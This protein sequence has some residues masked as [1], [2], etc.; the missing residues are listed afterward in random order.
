MFKISKNQNIVFATNS[1]KH[2]LFTVT[3]FSLIF[4][5]SSCSLFPSPSDLII[6]PSSN[7]PLLEI[8]SQFTPEKT[9]LISPDNFKNH[10]LYQQYD[11]DG[12]HRTEILFVYQYQ[13]GNH[14]QSKIEVK[15]IKEFEYGWD[16]IWS[17]SGY[18]SGM[19]HAELY[20]LTNNSIPEIILGWSS[21]STLEKGL[22]I[23]KFTSI[24]DFSTQKDFSTIYSSIEIQS[25]KE[26]DEE[27]SDFNKNE[28]IIWKK[29]KDEAFSVDI[30]RFQDSGS[31]IN[32]SL[33]AI[34]ANENYPYFFREIAS[35]YA[36]LVEKYPDETIYWYYYSLYLLYSHQYKEALDSCLKGTLS[37]QYKNIF[38]TWY[39]LEYLNSSILLKLGR[40]S[41][42]ESKF[43]SIVNSLSSIKQPSVDEKNVLCLSEISL[44][45]VNIQKKDFLSALLMLDNTI[46]FI[47]SIL[48]PHLKKD[49][50]S[51]I[52]LDVIIL[53]KDLQDT[54]CLLQSSY[55]ENFLEPHILDLQEGMNSFSLLS[56]LHQNQECEFRVNTRSLNLPFS[57]KFMVIDFSEIQP[58]FFF[59]NG[60]DNGFPYHTFVWKDKNNNFKF[61]HLFNCS[62][63][64]WPLSNKSTVDK[65][66]FEEETN[67]LLLFYSNDP[68]ACSFQW[69]NDLR[70]WH[71]AW[72]PLKNDWRGNNGEIKFTAS[73]LTGFVTEG[74]SVS[75][76]D[77]ANMIFKESMNSFFREFQDTWQF[78]SENICFYTTKTSFTKNAYSILVEYIYL[79]STMQYTL[80]NE[81]LVSENCVHDEIIQSLIQ[82]P[83]KQDWNI[84]SPKNIEKLD[85]WI[86]FKTGNNSI[87]RVVFQFTEN[88]VKIKSIEKMR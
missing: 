40:Y 44:A 72:F 74:I 24:L 9:F 77:K 81:Y 68:I 30:F 33:K 48:S 70:K 7:N 43:T 3:I 19:N 11:I 76:P 16:C 32:T 25:L 28:V 17:V 64:R 71:A 82:N 73:S 59:D 23:Y 54:Q 49:T 26:I 86:E 36:P 58:K 37:N 51:K 12:N 53:K 31:V 62:S 18:G 20:D 6:R 84:V 10:S 57:E 22:D 69:N 63:N 2:L 85:N 8:I 67:V 13:Q 87:F 50:L 75:N 66:F 14:E 21:G 34:P 15:I 65:I 5:L 52:P 4:S 56:D 80:S 47:D 88:S 42:A 45:K 39:D 60:V 35:H 61:Q 83:I 55:A 29:E 79:I 27:S 41:Q 1:F 78:D 38:P 46:V